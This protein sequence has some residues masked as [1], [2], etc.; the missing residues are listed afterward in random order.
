MVDALVDDH[1]L[2]EVR[3]RADVWLRSCNEEIPHKSLGMLTPVEYR[4]KNAHK[5]S[6]NGWH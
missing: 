6:G 3:E 4:L 2:S 5:T 1:G